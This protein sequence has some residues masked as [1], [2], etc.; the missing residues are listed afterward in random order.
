MPNQM[1]WS[2]DYFYLKIVQT[3]TIRVET[4]SFLFFM[5]AFVGFAYFFW[6]GF[7]C[8]TWVS[9]CTN[10]ESNLNDSLILIS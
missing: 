6:D 1:L 7:F 4:F 9:K 8:H 5:H 3:N 2:Q 10:L